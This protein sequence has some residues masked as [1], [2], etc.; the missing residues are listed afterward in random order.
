MQCDG[1]QLLAYL[2]VCSR[3]R[4]RSRSRV[5][6]VNFSEVCMYVISKV[7][8]FGEDSSSTKQQANQKDATRQRVVGAPTTYLP[9][10]QPA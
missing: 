2:Y 7:Y 5:T 10:H 3:V 6:Y 1:Q 9:K 4:R 8:V